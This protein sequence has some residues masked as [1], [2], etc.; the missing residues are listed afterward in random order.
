M[1]LAE[2]KLEVSLRP[3]GVYGLSESETGG[4]SADD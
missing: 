4:K 3:C 1:Q 2:K